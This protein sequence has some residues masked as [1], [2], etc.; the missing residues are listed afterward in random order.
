[1][2]T[3]DAEF[4]EAQEIPEKMVEKDAKTWH[5]W[6][7]CE[8]TF[9]VFFEMADTCCGPEMRVA[10]WSPIRREVIGCSQ[11]C[12]GWVQQAAMIVEGDL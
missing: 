3:S 9:R 11:E 6:R 8:T 4:N 1:M 2:R 12:M 10:V 7:Y 5:E